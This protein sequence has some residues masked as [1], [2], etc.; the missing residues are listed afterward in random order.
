MVQAASFETFVTHLS[1]ETANEILVMALAKGWWDTTHTIHIAG[2]EMT[3]TAYDFHRLISLR[4]YSPFV[5]LRHAS[6]RD[7]AMEL[8]GHSYQI[9]SFDT[10]FLPGSLSSILR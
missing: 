10:M 5:E 7:L 9:R 4:S 8:L 6:W 3:L 1:K 2:R